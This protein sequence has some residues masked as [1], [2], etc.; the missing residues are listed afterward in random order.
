MHQD[1]AVLTEF[2]LFRDGKPWKKLYIV[3][4]LEAFGIDPQMALNK[5]L[6]RRIQA[7]RKKYNEESFCDFG[8]KQHSNIA[9]LIC[10][11]KNKFDKICRQENYT[12][13]IESIPIQNDQIN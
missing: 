8:H 4:N 3:H 11:T 13:E 12:P 2:Q 1:Q 7:R 5:W 6:N 9:D 10:V